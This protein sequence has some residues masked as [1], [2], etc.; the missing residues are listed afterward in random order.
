MGTLYTLLCG[1]PPFNSK[2]WE[3]PIF[4]KYQREETKNTMASGG[5]QEKGE[6]KR[7]VTLQTLPTWMIPTNVRCPDDLMDLIK[8]LM[9]IDT[10]QR[11]K[12]ID[13]QA[14]PFLVVG[15]AEGE[16][17]EEEE[18]EEEAVSASL[19]AAYL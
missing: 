8:G 13:L 19:A 14:H 6:R 9:T 7:T 17:G 11:Y 2:P 1:N 10:D 5:T 16:E 3:C 12:I 15:G 4:A 18:E